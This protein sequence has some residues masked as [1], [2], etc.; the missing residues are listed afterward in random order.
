[1]TDQN[2]PVDSPNPESPNFSQE[3]FS[4]DCAEPSPVPSGT[5]ES[6]APRHLRVTGGMLGSL[7]LGGVAVLGSIIVFR[8]G[9]LPVFNTVFQPGPEWLS[10][11]RRTGIFL[12]ALAG[13]WV[14]VRGFEKRKVNELG[15]KPI[16]LLL[17]GGAG[18]GL[19]AMS[20]VMLFALGAYKLVLFRG[21]SPT[22][23]GV[24]ALI[25]IAATLEELVYRCLVFR[26]IERAW[27]TVPAL[28][29]QAVVFALPHLENVKDGRPR[30]VVTV[31]VS[32]TVLGLLWAGIF[33]LT[34]NLWV[35]VANHGAW[36]FTILLSGVPLSGIE[37]WRAIA[38]FES[39]SAGPDWLT[40]GIFGPE[41]SLLVIVL[42]TVAVVL[43]LQ[44][45]RRRGAFIKA[46]A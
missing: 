13:Y 20:L 8:Q 19:M 28:G 7:L 1:M 14:Y 22:L 3:A 16:P 34:R 32:C 26:I 31:L 38:P 40:G 17:G 4:H 39:R 45:A 12:A 37:D 9:L 44:I 35:A 24:A 46:A 30:D 29:I 18:S 33:V 41:S 10:V 23:L 5:A 27:G 11:M 43:L 6:V 36:N 21:V 2:Q 15:L 25:A 42:S